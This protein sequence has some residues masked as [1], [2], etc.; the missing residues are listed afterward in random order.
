MKEPIWI[1]HIHSKNTGISFNKI[2]SWQVKAYIDDC[3]LDPWTDSE[4]PRAHFG[5]EIT[6]KKEIKRILGKFI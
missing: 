3:N 4:N 2:L 6:D 1:N 5:P